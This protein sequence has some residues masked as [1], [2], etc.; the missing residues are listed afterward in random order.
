MHEPRR[1]GS[2]DLLLVH[3]TDYV[4]RFNRGQLSSEEIRK[5]GFPWSEAL[6]ERSYRAAGG[7]LEAAVHAMQHGLAMN[8]A[9]GTHHAFQATARGS[10]SSTTS[11]S[12]SAFFSVTALFAEPPSST[13]TCIR[14]TEP[15]RSSPLIL[16]YSRSA[17]MAARTTR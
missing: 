2:D 16:L 14:V 12:R 1:I 3:T 15:T 6:V 13:S 4:D 5:L 8:L 9:G 7:T 10:A 11:P 17:C